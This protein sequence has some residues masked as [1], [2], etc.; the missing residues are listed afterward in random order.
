MGGGSGRLDVIYDDDMTNTNDY[1][2]SEVGEGVRGEG[3]D[4]KRTKQ[5]RSGRDR[6]CWSC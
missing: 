5:G 4:R 3:Y 1:E 6:V 2:W